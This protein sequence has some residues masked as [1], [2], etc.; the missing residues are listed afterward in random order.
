MKTLLIDPPF[1]RFI[2][3]YNR[4]FPLGLASLAAVLQENGHEVLIYDADANVDRASEM[5]FSALESKYSEY[6][7]R[8]NN[9]NDELWNELRNVLLQFK[10]NLV[11]ISVFTAKIASA[12][13]AAQV[14]KQFDSN[15][16]IVI[17]GPHPTVRAE[18]SLK[19][20]SYVDFV[21]RRE[22][23]FTFLRLV[24]AIEN[25]KLYNDIEG[26]SFRSN[27]NIYHNPPAK[28]IQNLD[29]IPFPAR[30][31]LLHKNSYTSEDMGM[32]MTGRGCPFKCTFC[33]SSG[34]WCR[35]VRFRSVEN[36]IGEIQQVKEKYGTYQFAFKDDTF[37]LNRKRVHEF[38]RLIKEKRLKINWE[39]NVRANLI[40]ELCLTEMKSAGCNSVKL[41]VESGSDRI[42]S[43]VMEKGITV[44][45]IVRSSKL[46]NKAGI[47]WTGYFMIGLPGETKE[48]ILKTL[49]IMRRIKPN[50]ASLS[51]YEPFPG[52][53]LFEKGL[54]TNQ[55]VSERT[56]E[57]YCTISPKYYYIKNLGKRVET[58]SNE[59]LEEIEE[60]M[61]TS[62]YKHNRSPLRIFQRGKS[63]SAL[64][65]KKPE[66]LLDDF[67]KFLAWL[68]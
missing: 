19:I 10:P 67:K 26:V 33:S 28:Y 59:E 42:L 47:H 11:G 58:M 22:G 21:V 9:K 1:Y 54:A 50:F 53:K 8:V 44:E 55:V 39:C 13:I 7:R 51:V 16:P 24:E 45:Q 27:G 46:L 68:K 31:L 64:Y 43:E 3:Y 4:Y 15:I 48:E 65:L 60:F 34:V 30:D 20:S 62:F 37:T 29:Q 49:D 14:V 63:R 41:G 56:F 52:T 32:I 12:F 36:V 40:D 61:K 35:K 57:E 38:C 18:E 5:D 17:G 23:E 66:V 2:R 25:N 6:L